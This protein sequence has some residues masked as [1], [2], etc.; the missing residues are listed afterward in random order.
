MRTKW[1]QDGL[2]ENASMFTQIKAVVARSETLFE[3]F[4]GV[5]AIAVLLV[6]GLF[7]P[8]LL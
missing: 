3:D 4:M 6:I 1:Q 8:N 7:L 2:E 5:A